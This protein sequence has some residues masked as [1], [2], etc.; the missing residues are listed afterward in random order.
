M[1]LVA[2]V[3]GL[4]L[5]EYFVFGSLV[6]RARVQYKVDAPAVSGHPV[7]ERYFRVQQNTLELLVM[8]V[9][10]V[11]LF[12]IYVSATWAAV[13]GAI[14]IVGRILYLRTYVA[15]PKRCSAG[16]GLS[17]LPILVMIVGVLWAAGM[18]LL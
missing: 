10:A 7:F 6:G 12:G 11:W 18:K 9:P 4:A 3:I 15:D 14:Y 2:V 5:L 8:F 13:L 16:F 1:E 17:I